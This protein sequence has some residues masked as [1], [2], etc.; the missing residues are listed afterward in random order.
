MHMSNAVDGL[1]KIIYISIFNAL[2][3]WL[4]TAVLF[5]KQKPEKARQTA[6]ETC[7]STKCDLSA[8]YPLALHIDTRI[9]FSQPSSKKI[10]KKTED[11]EQSTL[12]ENNINMLIYT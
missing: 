8:P 1:A 5:S 4:F 12:T 2:K 9:Q 10:Q 7:A 6:T 11:C 3:N